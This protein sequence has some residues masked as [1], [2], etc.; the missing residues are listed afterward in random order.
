M[1]GGLSAF[2]A[3]NAVKPENIRFAASRRFVDEDG[4]PML[5][6]LRPLMSEEDEALRRRFTRMVQVPGKSSQFRQEFDSNGYLAAMAAGCTVFPNLN[7]KGL[8]D[9]YGVKC[10]EELISA[11]LTPGEYTNYTEKLFD[12]C[13]FGD[14]PDLVEQAKN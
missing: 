2:L 4:K 3:Q 5:W 12:I 13:G 14:A 6:E 9:S 10:A 8:Q 7:D 1:A 11:M